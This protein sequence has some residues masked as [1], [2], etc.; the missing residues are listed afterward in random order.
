MKNVFLL[1]AVFLMGI[2]TQAKTTKNEKNVSINT[3]TENRYNATEIISFIENGVL[4]KVTTTG[5]FD[6]EFLYRNN[7]PHRPVA[8]HNYKGR[9]GNNHYNKRR[10]DYSRNP[11]ITKDHY[12]TII[13]IGHTCI[14]YQRNG[15]VRQIGDTPLKYNRGKLI[16]VGGLDIFYNNRGQIHDVVGYINYYNTQT[17]INGVV[18]N[19]S[20]WNGFGNNFCTINHDHSIHISRPYHRG[21]RVRQTK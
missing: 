11:R 3:G 20:D 18:W 13:G 5:Q 4:Y 19:D 16:Q 15:K 17:Y 6:F 10:G 21:N 8:N 1:V 14:T 7:R 12:G 9:R 2:P